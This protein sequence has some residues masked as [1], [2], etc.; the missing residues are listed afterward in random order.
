MNLFLIVNFRQ[1]RICD[2]LQTMRPDVAEVL[3][4]RIHPVLDSI[5]HSQHTI[6]LDQHPLQHGT[7]VSY[8]LN[9][10]LR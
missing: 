5:G 8:G 4:S 1:Y 6:E 10:R 3:W 7:W 9:S 2:R